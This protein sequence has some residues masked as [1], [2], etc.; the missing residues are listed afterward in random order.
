MFRG[1]YAGG[2]FTISGTPTADGVFNYTVTSSGG[3]ETPS[4]SGTVTVVAIPAAPTV[5]SPV[6]YCPGDA[7]QPLTAQGTNLLWYTTATGGTGSTTAPTPS[8][9]TSGS[10][11]DYYVSQSTTAASCESPR[12]LITVVVSNPLIVDIGPDVTICQ[13]D[14]ARFTPTVTPAATAYQWV[15]VNASNNTI[16]DP[17]SLNTGMFPVDTTQYILRA[18]LGG[19]TAQDMVQVNVR[20][21]PIVEAGPNV[22]ICLND[23]TLLI[24]SVSHV[25]DAATPGSSPVYAWTPVDSLTTPN[26]IQTW[27]HPVHSTWY[28]LTATY[29]VADYGCDFAPFDSVKVVVQPVVHAFAGN[30]T[31][32]VKNLPHQL[33]GTGGVVYLWSSPTAIFSNSSTQNPTVTLNNDANI[34][35]RVE[36]A[37]GCYGLDSVFIKVYDG[38]TYYVPNAFSPNGDGLNDVFR[39]IPPGISS[40]VY[41]RIFDRYGQM[42]FETNQ[43][44]KGWDGTFNGKPAPQGVYVWTVKGVDRD[45]KT[46]EMKGTVTLVR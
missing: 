9:A 45:K 18:T 5:V 15:A 46:V 29:T 23:S 39:V 24:G 17:L 2:T 8:T 6:N 22:P 41:F 28:K 38:P 37:I 36:D 32:A 20:W 16:I 13:G 42:V 11:T 44:L 25:S 10:S 34:F 26:A 27:A 1:T 33:H 40:T 4:L 43:W 3:C 35:L 7:A 14:T 21:K 12:A 31:I 19:C 30:D